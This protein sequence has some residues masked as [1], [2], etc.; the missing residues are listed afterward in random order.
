MF[1][2]HSLN[3]T[4][5]I[6]VRLLH[7]QVQRSSA[8]VSCLSILVVWTEVCCTHFVLDRHHYSP[9]L[10][11]CCVM[12]LFLFICFNAGFTSLTER[13]GQL[14]SEGTEQMTK[15]VNGYF[16][17]LIHKIYD[18]SGDILKFAVRVCMSVLCI[19]HNLIG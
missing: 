18:H 6:T 9:K 3:T 19:M 7:P 11:F 12:Y 15:H 1:L 16:G 8:L 10:Q 5:K 4:S 2:A 17:K 13:M 14:G